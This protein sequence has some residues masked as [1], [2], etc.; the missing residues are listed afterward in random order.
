[1]LKKCGPYAINFEYY[2]QVNGNQVTKHILPEI[3]NQSC[4]FENQNQLLD[5][6]DLLNKVSNVDFNNGNNKQFRKETDFNYLNENQEENLNEEDDSNIDYNKKLIELLNFEYL[7]VARSIHYENRQFKR[8]NSKLLKR[9]IS[10]PML[11]DLV[12]S[13]RNSKFS[14]DSLQES[15]SIKSISI[16]EE[17]SVQRLIT[18][19]SYLNFANCALN[20]K[21]SEQLINLYVKQHLVDCN[22]DSNIDCD[23]FASIHWLGKLFAF[24]KSALIH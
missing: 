22:L 14:K 9:L 15:S 24:F 21:C 23:D 11:D 20:L 8:Q 7:P 5:T 19:A 3:Y 17:S 10:K 6:I 2:L 12:K 13:R 1:M 18:T 16:N 4:E